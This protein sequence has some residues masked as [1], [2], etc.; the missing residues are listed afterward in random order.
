MPCLLLVAVLPACGG[1]HTA[2]L[3]GPAAGELRGEGWVG[4]GPVRLRDP[5]P[6]LRVVVFFDPRCP[7][8]LTEVKRLQRLRD[9]APGLTIVGAT[10]SRDLDAIHAFRAKA[11][12]SWPAVYGLE[13][14]VTEHFRA[15]ASPSL[16]V[17][18]P[19]GRVVGR[20]LIALRA[21]LP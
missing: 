7:R 10:R 2:H 19:S 1:G 17:I 3:A 8:S 13:P 18:D 12:A 16:R 11:D 14:G 4:G 6:D 15:Q 21:M 9:L 5:H 20:D